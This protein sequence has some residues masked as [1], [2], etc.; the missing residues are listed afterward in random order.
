MRSRQRGLT[1]VEI[2]I[3]VG[4]LAMVLTTVIPHIASSARM[5][6]KAVDMVTIAQL[7][8]NLLQEIALDKKVEEGK[9]DG[10]FE[11]FDHV[12]WKTEISKVKMAEVFGEEFFK[13]KN[14]GAT[15]MYLDRL[16]RV[17]LLVEWEQNG[18]PMSYET[19]TLLF[20]ESE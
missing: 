8:R 19:Y 4:I 11:D 14:S 13:D 3:S 6:R 15:E 20:R 18:R 12:T 7:S 17:Q 16:Y 10:T 9:E 2:L 1:L 5:T